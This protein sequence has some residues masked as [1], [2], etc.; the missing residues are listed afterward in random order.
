M[1]SFFRIT[2]IL[3]AEEQER[4]STFDVD[5][6]QD[7]ITAANAEVIRYLESPPFRFKTEGITYSVLSIKQIEAPN[8]YDPIKYANQELQNQKTFQPDVLKSEKEKGDSAYNEL[9]LITIQH[10]ENTIGNLIRAMYHRELT[11][12]AEG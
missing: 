8:W 5:L 6:E 4:T 7:I 1:K 2:F 10:Y 11:K 3:T 12:K 9:D